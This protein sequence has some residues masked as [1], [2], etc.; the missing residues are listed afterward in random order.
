[1]LTTLAVV[2]PFMWVMGAL[3]KGVENIPMQGVIVLA[4]V[5]GL[6]LALRCA[7]LLARSFRKRGAV[8]LNR[9]AVPHGVDVPILCISTGDDEAQYGL[10]LLEHLA[11]LPIVLQHPFIMVGVFVGFMSAQIADHLPRLP[12]LGT[13]PSP[14]YGTFMY[15]L[16]FFLALQLVALVFSPVAGRIALG[17]GF[18][19]WPLFYN[20]FVRVAVTPTPLCYRLVDFIDIATPAVKGRSGLA[21]SRVYQD[22][23]AIRQIVL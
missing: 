21:H 19:Y 18:G 8:V 4:F 14:I 10:S 5:I 13:S 20:F 11:N 12:L 3:L 22:E 2:A 6:A 9:L 1:L 16:C 15:V 17:L 23:E 7:T